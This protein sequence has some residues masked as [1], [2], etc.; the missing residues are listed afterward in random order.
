MLSLRPIQAVSREDLERIVPGYSSSYVL[1]VGVG[2]DGES[3]SFSL[4]PAHLNRPFVKKHDYSAP[5]TMAH[6]ND[7]ARQGSSF[8]AFAEDKLVGLLLA[9]I[10]SW[11]STLAVREFGVDP[12]FRRQGI[13]KMLLAQC[14]ARAEELRLR[15]VL[16]ETQSTNMPAIRL[17][18]K[19]GFKIQGLDLALYDNHDQ[20]HGE[21]AIYLRKPLKAKG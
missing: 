18:E 20:E 6:Y 8:G 13:G 15:G 4:V 16:C 7:V 21:V 3:T 19:Q 12:A 2:Q 1:A 10:L 9:E 5:A 17:Y 14:I 11:N